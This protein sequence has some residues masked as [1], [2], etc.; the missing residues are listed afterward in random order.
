MGKSAVNIA[1][2]FI[3]M[4]LL[5]VIVCNHIVLFGVAVPLVFVYFIVRTPM[6]MNTNLLLTLSFLLGLCV[7][8]FSDT[9]GANAL[10]C[11]VLAMLKRPVFYAYIQHE[12]RMK[13]IIPNT[14]TLGMSNYCK[15][16]FTL[17]GIF[18][19]LV[20]TI[21]FFS[22]ADVKEVLVLAASSSVLTF[23]LLLGLDSLVTTRRDKR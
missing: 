12:D 5:Q 21:Q 10:A 23:A 9:P 11:T 2:L 8:I 19:L 6:D 13:D 16:L 14:V 7:D 4:L 18:C 20:F 3:S 15:Y 22:F 17:V 1:I